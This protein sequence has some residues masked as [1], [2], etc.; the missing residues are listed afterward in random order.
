MWYPVAASRSVQVWVRARDGGGRA[1]EAPVSVFVLDAGERAPELRAPPPALFL[2]EDAAPGTVLAEL[3][4]PGPPAPPGAPAPAPPRLRLAAARHPPDLFAL[5]AQG[6]LL[7]A[8][9]LDRE[10]DAYHVI[11]EAR[12]PDSNGVRSRRLRCLDARFASFQ[13]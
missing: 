8:G 1:G 7:L 5:D 3:Q 11:G 12:D 10:T 2:R 13:A 4:P 6:R 9:R